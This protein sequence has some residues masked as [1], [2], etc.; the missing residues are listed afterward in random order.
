MEPAEL[1]DASKAS[2][3]PVLAPSKHS[4]IPFPTCT[5]GRAQAEG[6]DGDGGYSNE[7]WSGLGHKKARTTPTNSQPLVEPA[8][9]HCGS[10]TVN[11]EGCGTLLSCPREVAPFIGLSTQMEMAQHDT[12]LTTGS[13]NHPPT[14]HTYTHTHTHTHTHTTHTHTH[15]QEEEM[16]SPG[17]APPRHIPMVPAGP[18]RSGTRPGGGFYPNPSG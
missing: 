15:T 13:P 7:P 5:C 9:Y 2:R 6:A 14:H 12:S 18:P 17:R 16:R 3:K 10:P 11:G 4:M 8:L 1:H